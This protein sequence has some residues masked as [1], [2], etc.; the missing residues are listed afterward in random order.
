ML[1]RIGGSKQENIQAS[2]C[3]SAENFSSQENRN[4]VSEEEESDEG[5]DNAD[6]PP[7]PSLGEKDLEM[8]K[9]ETP[10]VQL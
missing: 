9:V 1:S 5:L 2:N 7:F 3:Q 10:A 6:K 8:Q 4:V